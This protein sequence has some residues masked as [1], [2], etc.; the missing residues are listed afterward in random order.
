M[1]P[2]SLCARV[3]KGKYYPTSDFLSVTKKGEAQ[4]RGDRSSM[5]GMC[6]NGVKRVGLGGKK[7]GFSDWSH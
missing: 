3:L 4:Q 5:G 6:S 1:R 2:D 7:F